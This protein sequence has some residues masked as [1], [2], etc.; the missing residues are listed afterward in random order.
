MRVR[1]LFLIAWS[2]WLIDF[3]TKFWAERHLLKSINLIGDFLKLQLSTNSGAAFSLRVNSIFL[4]IFAV[5]VAA[6]IVYW[7]P[8]I[9]SRAWAITFGLVLGG[10]LGNLTDRITK[11]EV[12][13]WISFKFWPAFNIADA[14]I[15]IAAAIAIYLTVRNVPPIPRSRI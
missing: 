15:V 5:L 12:T 2:I 13:D 3:I 9:S 14:A 4:T 6:A 8:R 10:A 11:G 1:P 7:S